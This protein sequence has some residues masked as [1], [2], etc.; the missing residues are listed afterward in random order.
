MWLDREL[1]K[2]GMAGV[3]MTQRVVQDEAGDMC[4]E[5][6]IDRFVG[7]VKDLTVFLTA[8]RGKSKV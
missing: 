5:H 8:R 4:R 3:E 2:A 1:K 7:L 6:T